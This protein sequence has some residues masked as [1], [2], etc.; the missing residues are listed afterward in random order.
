[1]H[2]SQKGGTELGRADWLG[3]TGT[4][5]CMQAF[6]MHTS[7]GG[8]MRVG[9]EWGRMEPIGWGELRLTMVRGSVSKQ[10]HSGW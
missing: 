1:M 3:S 7:Q 8:G 6:D 5:N 2:T 9:T 4:E 10:P